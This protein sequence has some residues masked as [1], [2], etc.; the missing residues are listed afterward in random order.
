M[1]KIANKGIVV[2][3]IVAFC[4]ISF[5]PIPL[6]VFLVFS[7]NQLLAEE[8]YYSTPTS[9]REKPVQK[10]KATTDPDLRWAQQY[11]TGKRIVEQGDKANP[12]VTVTWK[13]T[14]EKL[15]AKPDEATSSSLLA[16]ENPIE[17][18]EATGAEEVRQRNSGRL[19]TGIDTGV[20]NL[21]SGLLHLRGYTTDMSSHIQ[22]N[23]L[24]GFM[25]LTPEL[26]TE[27]QQVGKQIGGGVHS[28]MQDVGKEMVEN[29]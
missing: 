26:K 15:H 1:L 21:E 3:K 18:N 5:K 25:Y 11:Y 12:I 16:T 28:I 9:S 7:A 10:R 8:A 2:S 14:S 22:K 23:G 19:P 13:K 20:S 24:K 27:G 4:Q 17:T 6:L 29:R